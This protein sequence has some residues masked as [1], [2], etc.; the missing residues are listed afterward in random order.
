M[1]I[2]VDKADSEKSTQQAAEMI[3]E[4]KLSFSFDPKVVVAVDGGLCVKRVIAAADEV[5]FELVG[6]V[7]K[8][9]K[10]TESEDE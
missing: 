6:R 5:G 3:E 10:F 9:G 1:A 7:R 8:E 2:Q 4:F